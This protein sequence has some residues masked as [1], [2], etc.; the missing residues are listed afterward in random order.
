MQNNIPNNYSFALHAQNFGPWALRV[1]RIAFVTMGFTAAIIVGC[2]ASLSFE[3]SLQTFLSIIGYW[4]VIH[5]TV[6]AEEHIIFRGCRW[7]GYDFDNWNQPTLL[8]FGWGAIGAF[9]FGFLGAALG[10]NVTWYSAPI[11]KLIG[12]GANIGHEL[13]FAFS[14][15][16]FPIFRWMEKRWTGK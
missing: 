5:I 9:L 2:L 1:P 6:V 8:P 10:M 16:A 11:A 12:G 15:I 3:S 13:S 14:A 7:S 4:T